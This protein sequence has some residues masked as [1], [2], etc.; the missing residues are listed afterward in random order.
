MDGGDTDDK[1]EEGRDD[2][3][4]RFV[5]AELVQEPVQDPSEDA[6]SGV[7]LFLKDKRHLVGQDIP[8]NT[9]CRGGH[10]THHDGY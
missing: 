6:G 9:T 5:E 2:G 8:D 7:D 4:E 10:N 3:D 1:D